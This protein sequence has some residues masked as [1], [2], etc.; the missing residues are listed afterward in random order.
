MMLEE[1][2]Y[3]SK[4]WNEKIV[5]LVKNGTLKNISNEL[6]DGF[7]MYGFSFEILLLDTDGKKYICAGNWAFELVIVKL[8]KKEV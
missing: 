3:S 8:Y 1:K 4:E 6:A 2:N 5:P 7:L